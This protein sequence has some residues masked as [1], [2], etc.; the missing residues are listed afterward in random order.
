MNTVFNMYFGSTVTIDYS[1]GTYVFYFSNLHALLKYLQK[2]GNKLLLRT[3]IHVGES[4]LVDYRAN[5]LV[6]SRFLG[7]N[8]K[9]FKS[10]NY[11]R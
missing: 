3:I 4:F 7:K 2:E 5:L 11:A 6:Q 1:K 9:N 8:F 10:F